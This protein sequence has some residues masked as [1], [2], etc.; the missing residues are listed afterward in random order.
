MQLDPAQIF[1]IIILT[2][3][4]VDQNKLFNI[5]I[6]S[7]INITIFNVMVI[8]NIIITINIIIFSMIIVVIETIIFCIIINFFNLKRLSYYHLH[9][10]ENH[11]TYVKHF[12]IAV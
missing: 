11:N 8:I 5:N 2:S 6:T 9:Q 3:Q 1:I 4:D 7:I 12:P 10:P